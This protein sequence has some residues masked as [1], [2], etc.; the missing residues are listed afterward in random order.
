LYT[1]SGAKANVSPNAAPD[2]CWRVTPAFASTA[3]KRTAPAARAFSC[4]W[5]KA[6]WAAASDG[7]WRRA[8]STRRSSSALPNM[9]H[10]CSGTAA[11]TT[12]RCAAPATLAVPAGSG[13]AV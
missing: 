12:K 9:V 13:C 8:V 1:V 5:R 2:C 7:L 3:G 11:S 6:A 4:A 10:Q